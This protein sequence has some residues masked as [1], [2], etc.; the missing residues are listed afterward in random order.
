MTKEAKRIPW[1]L[2]P[3]LMAAGALWVTLSG[4][5]AMETV[6]G[7]FTGAVEGVAEVAPE[8]IEDLVQ[9]MWMNALITLGAGAVAGG[10][11]WFEVRRRQRKRAARNTPTPGMPLG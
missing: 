7:F 2:G 11:A 10:V 8:A 4:C 1:W 9:G 6:G 3:L 5:A